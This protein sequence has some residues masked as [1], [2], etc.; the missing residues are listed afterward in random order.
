M[1]LARY[2][3]VDFD[4]VAWKS[5]GH[6]S[7]AG[8]LIIEIAVGTPRAEAC[9]MLRAEPLVMSISWRKGYRDC[10]IIFEIEQSY[11]NPREN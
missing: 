8:E 4:F 10:Y 5:T 3:G 1:P 11:V 2:P 7:S 9:S 6:S